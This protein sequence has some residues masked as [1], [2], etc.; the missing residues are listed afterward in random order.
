MATHWQQTSLSAG[1]VEVACPSWSCELAERESVNAKRHVCLSCLGEGASPASHREH[2]PSVL[3]HLSWWYVWEGGTNHH[4]NHRQPY[5]GTA[6]LRTKMT[7]NAGAVAT[8]GCQETAPELQGGGRCWDS[9]GPLRPPAAQMGSDREPQRVPQR[10]P[11]ERTHGGRSGTD[12]LLRR[13][14]S[15]ARER[16]RSRKLY[17]TGLRVSPGGAGSP[18]W[19]G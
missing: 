16:S 17:G 10:T 11:P 7:D 5:S 6:L 12:R 3:Y 9:T 1:A 13:K 14:V 8:G 18:G 15:T 2:A 4:K 19:E